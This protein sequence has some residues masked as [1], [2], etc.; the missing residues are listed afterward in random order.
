MKKLIYLLLFIISIN[1]ICQTKESINLDT[2]KKDHSP[3]SFQTLKERE[4]QLNTINRLQDKELTEINNNE[5]SIID[6]YYSDT[7]KIEKDF[8][9]KI[10][11]HEK[12]YANFV[13]AEQLAFYI[14]INTQL[15]EEKNNKL[16][17]LTKEFNANIENITTKIENII[18]EYYQSNIEHDKKR[19][20]LEYDFAKNTI[21]ALNKQTEYLQNIKSNHNQNF[22]ENKPNTHSHEYYKGS[23]SWHDWFF[24]GQSFEIYSDE[25]ETVCTNCLDIKGN[26]I[27][28]ILTSS[29]SEETKEAL[30]FIARITENIEP[31]FAC[32]TDPSNGV[33][34]IKVGKDLRYRKTKSGELKYPIYDGQFLD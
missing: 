25:N 30:Q 26:I 21:D 32:E 27:A 8:K 12:S 20:Q 4:N 3:L 13:S 14:K 7:K 17:D 1:T 33:Q 10:N 22:L 18:E 34:I 31:G 11:E 24:N 5:K 28:A 19:A 29:I 15:I 2:E 23:C 6:K 16:Q 9:N